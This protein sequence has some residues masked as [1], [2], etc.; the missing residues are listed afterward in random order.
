MR[1]MNRLIAFAIAFVS[2]ALIAPPANAHGGRYRYRDAP[3]H[4]GRI[5][6]AAVVGVA[7]G[8]FAGR[9]SG[10]RSRDRG[11]YDDDR[12]YAPRRYESYRYRE[13]YREEYRSPRYRDSS[14]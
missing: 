8:Y 6:T 13:R 11:Y 9:E 12:D 10:K 1:W 5:T 14:S 7:V 3:R 2:L 4:K